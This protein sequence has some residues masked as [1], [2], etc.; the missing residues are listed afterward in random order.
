MTESEILERLRV[1]LQD[2]FLYMKPDYVLSD[3]DS[4]LKK[5]IVDSMGVMD[6]LGFISETFGVVPADEE[7]TEANL[8]TPRAIARF[9]AGKLR[10]PQKT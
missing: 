1:F 6:V 4:L 7:V 10:A 2:T 9:V 8:G 5:G 3:D